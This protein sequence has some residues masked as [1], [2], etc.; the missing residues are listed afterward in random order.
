METRAR[1]VLIGAFTLLG[2]LGI[3]VFLLW[4]GKA[5][6]DRQF[7]YYDVLFD[8]VAGI[9]R[10]SEVRCAGLGVVEGEIQPP[11]QQ[12]LLDALEDLGEE[13]AAH[14][15]HDDADVLGAPRGQA[16]RVRGGHVADGCG[17]LLHTDARTL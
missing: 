12:R 15:G 6:S 1:Y 5:Q 7:S 2:F 10:G 14:V 9:S 16:D 11:L 13:P 8:S 4:F 3:L 17:H